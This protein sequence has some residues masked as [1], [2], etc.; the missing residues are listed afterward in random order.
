MTGRTS[1]ASRASFTAHAEQAQTPTAALFRPMVALFLGL[2]ALTAALLALDWLL[3]AERFAVQRIR[4]EGEFRH[5]TQPELDA[6]VREV[7]RGNILLLDLAA[8]RRAVESL[9]WVYSAS[10]RR[11]WPQDLDVRFTEQR[12]IAR[13]GE[14]AWVNQGDRVVR[15]RGAD[16]P[17]DLPRLDGPEGAQALV[18]ERF[19]AFGR[20]LTASGRKLDRLT[21]T[22]RRSWRLDL[23]TGL[24]LVLDREVPERKLERF[25]RAYARGFAREAQRMKQVDLRY[26]NGFAVQWRD[27]RPIPGMKGG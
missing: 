20:I 19:E 14:D 7:A 21:L 23:D 18:R 27:A 11:R 24:T 2:A 3:S 6:A 13:W 26:T 10:V 16:L 25:A 12:L 5:V 8:V 17:R 9:P 1:E 22:P 15:V 4:F